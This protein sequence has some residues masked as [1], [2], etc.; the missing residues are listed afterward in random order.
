MIKG[1][2][3]QGKEG[4]EL[5]IDKQTEIITLLLSMKC[6]DISTKIMNEK[7]CSSQPDL[8][9]TS[10]EGVASVDTVVLH[11]KAIDFYKG[12]V[13]SGEAFTDIYG[14]VIEMVKYIDQIT[15]EEV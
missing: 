10:P 5:M 2:I 11:E 8:V 12:F 6:S 13:K 14:T 3:F 15:V 4:C 7:G 9:W 1:K